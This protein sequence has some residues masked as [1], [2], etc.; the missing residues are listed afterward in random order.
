MKKRLAV[1]ALVVSMG[2]ALVGGC[3]SG[4][5][6]TP[7][8]S[9][10]TATK[11]E[12]KEE[13]NSKS[14]DEKYD[15]SMIVTD[16]K[17]TYA[18][19]LAKATEQ[20]A[21]ENFPEFNFTVLDGEGSVEK[22][23]SHMENCVTQEVDMIIC[24]SLDVAALA[25]YI[26]DA[27]DGGIPVCVV[28]VVNTGSPKASNVLADGVQQGE[29]P[30]KLAAKTIPENGKVV[31]LLGP[32][33]EIFS[34]QRMEGYQNELF[35]KRTDITILDTQIANWSKDEA[36]IIMEDWLQRFDDIDAVISMNDAMALGAI[37][38]AKAV[39]RMDEM[40]FYGIDGLIDAC[41]SV[42]QGE[43]TCSY[44]QNAFEQGKE[45][46]NVCRKVLN[47]EIENEIVYTDGALITKET[48]QEWIDYHK[49][50]GND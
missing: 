6:D 22:Q 16:M 3:S 41:Y 30:G 35:S 47:G 25:P 23:I 9:S 12:S 26:N 28:N 19:W 27:I 31:V 39:G 50:M 45:S 2:A 36:M 1:M 24:Q 38:A 21:A 14:K 4:G 8:A 48:A 43:L 40:T 15:V 37:E 32:S 49:S 7:D 44:L 17:A 34:D 18:A 5:K 10:S 46:L 33:G 42:Q 11:S 20:E 29:E 13:A